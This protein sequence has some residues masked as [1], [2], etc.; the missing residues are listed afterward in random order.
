[1]AGDSR[2]GHF[3]TITER[4]VGSIKARTKRKENGSRCIYEH[5]RR[6]A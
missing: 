5:P 4:V 3:E 1:M 2:N 6:G